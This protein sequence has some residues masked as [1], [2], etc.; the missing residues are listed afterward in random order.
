MR[1]TLSTLSR[2]FR[3][4]YIVIRSTNTFYVV[5]VLLGVTRS[6]APRRAGSLVWA[7]TRRLYVTKTKKYSR[8]TIRYFVEGGSRGRFARDDLHPFSLSSRLAHG[9]P[10]RSPFP[11]SALIPF[12]AIKADAR[13]PSFFLFLFLFL[14]FLV[15]EKLRNSEYVRGERGI[16]VLCHGAGNAVIDS[17]KRRTDDVL[18]H[19]NT[20]ARTSVAHSF[21]SLRDSPVVYRRVK[22]QSGFRIKETEITP[23]FGRNV[24]LSLFLPPDEMKWDYDWR[25]F[26]PRIILFFASDNKIV[27]NIIKCEWII[28]ILSHSAV[29][30]HRNYAQNPALRA[31]FSRDTNLCVP[32]GKHA[33]IT[34]IERSGGIVFNAAALDDCA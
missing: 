22:I 29:T 23:N 1:P 2:S 18:S 25:W 9:K 12:S 10:H 3:E 21:I 14:L 7:S 28:A 32:R 6:A 13:D 19:V 16:N 17:Q 24:S 4:F 20:L 27:N 34:K 30:P 11:A 26:G 5:S 8:H 31:F 15:V 33:A